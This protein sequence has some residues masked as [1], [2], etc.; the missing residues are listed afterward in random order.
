MTPRTPAPTERCWNGTLEEWTIRGLLEWLHTEKRTAMLRVGEGLDACVVFFKEGT[1]YRCEWGHKS[2]DLGV[3]ALL[4]LE[5]GKFCL[6]QRAFPEPLRN[7]AQDTPTLLEL[8][9]EAP[10]AAHVA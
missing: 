5:E 1:I 8:A 3:E 10:E 6:I 9:S 2:G 7:V 4:N